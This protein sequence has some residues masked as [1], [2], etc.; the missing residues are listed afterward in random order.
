MEK[1]LSTAEKNELQNLKIE[2]AR[3]LMQMGELVHEKLR[4]GFEMDPSL[5]SIS[6]EVCLLDKSIAT[7]NNSTIPQLGEGVCPKCHVDIDGDSRFCGSCGLDIKTYYEN[8][9]CACGVCGTSNLNEA[10]YCGTCGTI[11][12]K[13]VPGHDM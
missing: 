3:K 11:L 2:K 9:V 8:S 13:K 12:E 1:T 10:H 7:M 6:K 4:M 5:E